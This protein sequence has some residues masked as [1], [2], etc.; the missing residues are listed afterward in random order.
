MSSS[1]VLRC[2]SVLGGR[3]KASSRGYTKALLG[4]WA[5][6]VS[7]SIRNLLGAWDE[8]LAKFL[9]SQEAF[10]LGCSSWHLPLDSR[11]PGLGGNCF[12]SENFLS[13]FRRKTCDVGSACVCGHSSLLGADDLILEEVTFI[14]HSDGSASIVDVVTAPKGLMEGLMPCLPCGIARRFDQMYT[15]YILACRREQMTLEEGQM[16]V[17]VPETMVNDLESRKRYV[18]LGLDDSS[19]EEDWV[20]RVCRSSTV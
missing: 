7:P 10:P 14:F 11:C 13:V 20:P 12:A 17:N 6:H 16:T 15:R 2:S 19:D 1:S 8:A 3:K 5:S 4:A 18:E 9:V